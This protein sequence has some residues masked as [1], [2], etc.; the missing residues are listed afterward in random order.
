MDATFALTGIFYSIQ[1]LGQ[2]IG[3]YT[4]GTIIDKL[5]REV[6]LIG[7]AASAVFVFLHTKLGGDNI[8]DSASFPLCSTLSQ[9]VL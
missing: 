7:M 5:G 2:L 8:P 4:W 9:K 1:G 3:Y 6:T